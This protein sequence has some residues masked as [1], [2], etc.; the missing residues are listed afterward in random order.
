MS[1]QTSNENRELPQIHFFNARI[2]SFI[3]H[4]FRV[5]NSGGAAESV[6]GI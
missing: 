2:V 4:K 1:P 5:W 3:E 6:Y